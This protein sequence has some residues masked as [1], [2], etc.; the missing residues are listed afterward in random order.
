VARFADATL[1][2]GDR[3]EVQL[4]VSRSS[5]KYAAMSSGNS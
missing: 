3:A 2:M 1:F 5:S 4:A